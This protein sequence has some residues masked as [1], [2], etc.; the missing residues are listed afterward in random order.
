ME[1]TEAADRMREAAVLWSIGDINA[2]ELVTIA[3]DLLTAGRSDR[4]LIACGGN[5]S[6][7]T[8]PGDAALQRSIRRP[9][10]IARNRTKTREFRLFLAIFEKYRVGP[11]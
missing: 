2:A 7:T 5:P 11:C 3:C 9:A 8:F 1:P 10:C 4:P 6:F